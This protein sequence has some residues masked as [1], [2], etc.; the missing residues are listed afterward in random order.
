MDKSTSFCFYANIELVMTELKK[1]KGGLNHP[2]NL[3]ADD[4]AEGL[5]NRKDFGFYLHVAKTYPHL[6]LR[7]ILS[8]AKEKKNPPAWFRWRIKHDWEWKELNNDS[9]NRK[10]KDK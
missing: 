9:S 5:K 7:Q 8:E 6:Y 10:G 3:L 1:Q 2:N 4:L